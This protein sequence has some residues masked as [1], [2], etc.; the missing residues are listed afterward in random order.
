MEASL[1]LIGQNRTLLLR[2][3]MRGGVGDV[4]EWFKE[5]GK[6]RNQSE[7]IVNQNYRQAH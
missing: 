4:Y 6:A 2:K 5:Q 3:Y 7:E 1:D